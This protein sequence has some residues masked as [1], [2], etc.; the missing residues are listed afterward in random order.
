MSKKLF[1]AL[2][3][4]VLLAILLGGMYNGLVKKSVAVDTAWAQVENVLQRRA[5]LIPNLV[6]TVKGYAKHEKD[7]FDQLAQARAHYAGATSVQGKM[8]AAD[9]MGGALSRL[10]VIVENYPNLKANETFARLM[11]ELAGTENRIAVERKRYNEAVQDYDVS[12]RRLPYN[13]IA[14]PMGF[15]EKPFFQ[16]QPA[17][18][19]VPKVDF[20]Q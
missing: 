3:V 15:K 19:E 17:A 13:L 1:G 12:I 8:A 2:A 7:I 4:L 20:S 6:A 5:D 16:A 11:D 14:G 9:E 18:Q 10:M